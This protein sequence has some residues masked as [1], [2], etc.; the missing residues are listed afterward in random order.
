MVWGLLS[1]EPASCRFL[2]G[3]LLHLALYQKVEA[4][5]FFWEQFPKKGLCLPW[6]QDLASKLGLHWHFQ[7]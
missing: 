4:G 1:E 7:L 5:L 3:G 6:D 2:A